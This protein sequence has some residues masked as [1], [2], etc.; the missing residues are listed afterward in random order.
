[1]KGKMKTRKELSFITVTMLIAA[2]MFAGCSKSDE[3]KRL[4]NALNEWDKISAQMRAIFA[5]DP[6]NR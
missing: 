2:V 1:M 3:Q 5:H 4:K 6:Q